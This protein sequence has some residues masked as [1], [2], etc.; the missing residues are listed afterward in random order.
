MIL[1]HPGFKGAF[2]SSISG[3]PFKGL[4]CNLA[5]LEQLTG[6]RQMWIPADNGWGNCLGIVLF[7][8]SP[9]NWFNNLSLSLP[10]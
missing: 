8:S 7:Y 1:I 4:I 5:C 6:A 3:Y 9:F 2:C 10:S